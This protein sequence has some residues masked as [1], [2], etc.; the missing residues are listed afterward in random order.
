MAQLNILGHGINTVV[1]A[2]AVFG[3]VGWIVAL[4]GNIALY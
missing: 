3:M 1:L 2:V 4:A